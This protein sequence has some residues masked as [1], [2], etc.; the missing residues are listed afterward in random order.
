MCM[1][2]SKPF[3]KK[4]IMLIFKDGT[5]FQQGA[6]MVVLTCDCAGHLTQLESG[7]SNRIKKKYAKISNDYKRRCKEKKVVKGELLSYV[8]DGENPLKYLVFFPTRRLFKEK[9][10]LKTLE[11]GLKNLAE[12]IE[13]LGVEGVAMHSFK[14]AAQNLFWFETNRC[15]EQ[16]LQRAST[17][18][19]IT[20]LDVN[21]LNSVLNVWAKH[22]P[23]NVPR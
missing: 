15:I 16:T 14:R 8:V 23:H 13:S 9:T 17:I 3:T 19:R 5:L 11:K 1:G 22:N 2:G 10:E 18:S 21:Y 4:S 7:L 6:E 20:V 12:L